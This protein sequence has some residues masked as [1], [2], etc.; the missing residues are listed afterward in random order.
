MLSQHAEDG[1]HE[2]FNTLRGAGEGNGFTYILGEAYPMAAVTENF[3]LICNCF[4]KIFAREEVS[5]CG[6]NVSNVNEI[7]K[8]I[9]GIKEEKCITKGAGLFSLL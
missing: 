7:I 5:R 2:V 6:F 8:G 4:K 1:E 3:G 9:K